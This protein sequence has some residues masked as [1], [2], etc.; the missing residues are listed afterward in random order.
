VEDARV[1]AGFH[2]RFSCEDGA[3]LGAQIADYITQTLMQP[4]HG[5][6]VGQVRD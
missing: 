5:N 1:W 6:E 4:L 2:Y 3:T